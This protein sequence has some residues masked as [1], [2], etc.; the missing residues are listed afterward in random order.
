MRARTHGKL[1]LAATLAWVAFWVLGLP[2]YYRQ[3]SPVAMAWFVS[4][5][6]PPLAGLCVLV[7]RRVAP[8][9]RMRHALWTAF[10][11]S[12]PLA[13][14]DGLYCGLYLGHGARFLSL[15]WYLTV[16]YL[17]PWLALPAAAAL[18]GTRPATRPSP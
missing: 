3:Y 12:V 13:L 17:F 16:Y 1:A 14:Y 6:A 10:W 9:R 7:L 4:L 8:E 5:L 15:Y 18:L 11:F 2:S